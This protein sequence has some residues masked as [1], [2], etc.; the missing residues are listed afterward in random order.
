MFIFNLTALHLFPLLSM[1]FILGLGFIVLFKNKYSTLN[2][3]FFLISAVFGIWQFG[4]FMMFISSNDQQ[5][6]FW[7]RFIYLGV[8]FMPAL[9]YHFSLIFT[10]TNK[11][12]KALLYIS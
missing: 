4:T 2:R 11:N 5:I 6:I 10:Y 3:L 12:R 9:Q 8:V 1:I 7:D